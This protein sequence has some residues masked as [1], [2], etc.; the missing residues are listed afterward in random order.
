V[1]KTISHNLV[2]NYGSTSTGGRGIY[3]DDEMSYVTVTSNLVHGSGEWA[4]QIHGGDHNVFESNI[5]D[6][7]GA[8]LLGL[9]QENSSNGD[10]GMAGNV[11]TCNIVYSSAS[12]PYELWQYS[13]GGASLALPSVHDNI[14]WGT[15]GALPN[16]GTIV[17]T[18]P[19]VA[20]PGFVDPANGNY[21]FQ[22]GPPTSCAFQPIDLA[23]VGP[24]PH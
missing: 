15:N 3:L 24:L 8:E 17:D 20:N 19:S 13:P 2:S 10:F 1:T 22:S 14:Y 16:S 9:Y 18:S 4:L 11:F 5:F 6:I 21:A 7:S 23:G 12:P